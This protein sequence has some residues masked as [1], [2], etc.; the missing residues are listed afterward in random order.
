MQDAVD[1]ETD[2]RQLAPRLDVNIRRALLEG[3]LQEPVDD[4]DDVLVVGI[5][6]TVGAAE[7]NQLLERRQR[8]GA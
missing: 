7:F 8:A 6:L 2:H 4:I 1:A 3:I 5:E